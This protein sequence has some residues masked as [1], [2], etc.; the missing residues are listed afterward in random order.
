MKRLIVLGFLVAGLTL[1]A[2]PPVQGTVTHGIT[3]K[4]NAEDG[5]FPRTVFEIHVADSKIAAVVVRGTKTD[6][7]TFASR[8]N[9]VVN[10]VASPYVVIP[11]SQVSTFSFDVLVVGGTYN[12]GN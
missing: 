2:Q 8:P 6:G 4:V 1:N 3:Y 7:T 12:V 10:G 5:L 11:W 9:S